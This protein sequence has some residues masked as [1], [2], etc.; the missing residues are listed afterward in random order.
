MNKAEFYKANVGLVHSVSRKGFNR[1]LAAHVTIDYEDVFQEMSI[2]FLRACDGFDESRGFKFS[3]FYFRSAFNRLNTWVQDLIDDRMHYSN[4]DDMGGEDS[5]G[6]ESVIFKD[7]DTPEGN[8]AVSQMIDHISKS[9]S[10]L[11]YLIFAWSLTPPPEIVQ[12]VRKAQLQAEFGRALGYNTRC[13]VQ[14]SPRYIGN[15]IRMISNASQYEVDAALKEIDRMK[16]SDL[17]Q[18][19]G[20]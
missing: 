13:M 1:L 4:I 16:Y 20:A 11:A 17:K 7:L 5:E 6:L 10:P 15:F 19:A 2:V 3:T 8:Y 14:L 18:F 12:E 9:L